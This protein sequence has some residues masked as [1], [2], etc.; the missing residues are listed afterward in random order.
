MNRVRYRGA[1]GQD[2]G[3]PED[4]RVIGVNP[5]NPP[6][7]SKGNNVRRIMEFVNAHTSPKMISAPKKT[8]NGLSCSPTKS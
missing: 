7:T 4:M 2:G 3:R 8:E 1:G 5:K 6:T